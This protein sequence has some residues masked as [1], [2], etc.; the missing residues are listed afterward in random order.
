M[1]S[2]IVVQPAGQGCWFIEQDL[3][4]D[5]VWVHQRYVVGKKFLHLNDRVRYNIAPNHRKIG[6]V[7]AVDVEIIGLMITRQVSAPVA[8]GAR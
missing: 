5:C 7:M 8:G 2:G 1:F 4:R 3:T 6:E